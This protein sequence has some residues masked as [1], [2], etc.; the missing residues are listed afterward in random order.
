MEITLLSAF[1]VGF[2][3]STHCAGMCG[4]IVFALQGSLKVS[5]LQSTVIMMLA[6][7]IGRLT[8]YS[9]IGGIVGW[10]GQ[11]LPVY[12]M[13]VDIQLGRWLVGLFMVA[14]GVYLAGWFPILQPL[15]QLGSKLW[16]KIQPIGKKLLPIQ[17]STQAYIAG[18]IWG[19]LPCGMV[20]SMVVWALVVASPM[21][22]A[23]LML[24]FG[25]GTLPML[26]AI[27]SFSHYLRRLQTNAGFR[28]FAGMMIIGFGLSLLLLPAS[29]HYDPSLCQ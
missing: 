29:S 8:T 14:L 22:S 3:G 27:G 17:S 13:A 18:L 9:L 28:Y 19:W 16:L 23:L 11:S 2:L 5:Q 1:L 25:A 15:E 7:H 12:E 24:V 6:Y 20:Y 21:Q 26:F 4:G 10:L